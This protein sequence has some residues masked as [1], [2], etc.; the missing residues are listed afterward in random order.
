MEEDQEESIV[1]IPTTPLPAKKTPAPPA[2]VVEAEEPLVANGSPTTPSCTTRESAAVEQQ[3]SQ[4]VDESEGPEEA[5]VP[6]GTDSPAPVVFHSRKERRKS[7]THINMTLLI[8]S[9]ATCEG[10]EGI[11]LQGQGSSCSSQGQG[12][13]EDEEVEEGS[14]E[15]SKG[16]G[17]R[18]EGEGEEEEGEGEGEEEEAAQEVNSRQGEET[19]EG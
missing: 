10:D 11:T 2:A 8:N 6:P 3:Y 18:E 1:E 5:A 13:G 15:D 4:P 16:E 7:F 9:R 19:K 12:G 14:K 17:G